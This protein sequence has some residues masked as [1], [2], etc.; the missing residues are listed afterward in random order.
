MIA[1][2]HGA[3]ARH[4]FSFITAHIALSAHALFAA[5]RARARAAARLYRSLRVCVNA[6]LDRASHSHIARIFAIIVNARRAPPL[7]AIISRIVNAQ[8]PLAPLVCALCA[9]VRARIYRLRSRAASRQYGVCGGV[10]TMNN[11]IVCYRWR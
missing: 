3:Y 6:P 4:Q 5:L 8:A 10:M 9:C 7:C 2:Q 1:I 11:G